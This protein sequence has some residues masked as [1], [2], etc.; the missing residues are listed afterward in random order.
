MQI[1]F[2]CLFVYL[3]IYWELA[4]QLTTG[5]GNFCLPKKEIHTVSQ[6]LLTLSQLTPRQVSWAI[7]LRVCK[8]AGN[9]KILNC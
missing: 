3:F 2:I 6:Y 7:T 4:Y 1:S 8:T 5:V 9:K